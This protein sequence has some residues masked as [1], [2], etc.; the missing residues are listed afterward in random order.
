MSGGHFHSSKIPSVQVQNR[1]LIFIYD[2]IN[3]I[4]VNFSQI[5]NHALGKILH[6]EIDVEENARSG[7]ENAVQE[8]F[9]RVLKRQS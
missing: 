1:I 8:C 3:M 2:I 9:H 7:E 5:S 6:D 4:I